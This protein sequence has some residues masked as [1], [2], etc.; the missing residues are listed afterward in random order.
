MHLQISVLHL[1]CVVGVTD[2]MT[3]ET[4][5]MS[6]DARIRHVNSTSSLVRM[7]AVSHRTSNAM[8]IM[9]VVM[10]QMSCLTCATLQP[11]PALL[12]SSG[13]TMATVCHPAK[14]VTTAMTAMITVMRKAVV[15]RCEK[16][17]Y[18]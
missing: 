14:C 16:K 17:Q 5:A 18:S 3:V 9:T 10:N 8:A 1:F 13:V 15:S 4:V 7:A 2:G 6:K 12:E 11:L